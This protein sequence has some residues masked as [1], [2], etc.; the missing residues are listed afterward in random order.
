M[1]Y[2]GR[3]VGV[4]LGKETT[5]GTAVAASYFFPLDDYDYDD[6]AE[7]IA[8]EG[9]RSRIEASFGGDVVKKWGEGSLSGA[10]YN[11]GFGLVLLS[12]FG[13][14]T[15]TTTSGESAVY[16]HTFSVANSNEHQSLTISTDDSV[17]TDKRYAGAVVTSLE[18]KGAAGEYLTFNAGFMGNSEAS[19]TNTASYATEYPFRPQDI[20]F[21]LASAYSGLSGA[22]ATSIRS[23]TFKIEKNVEANYNLGSTSPSNFYNKQFTATLDI[24]ILHADDTYRDLFIAGTTRALQVTCA[25]TGV[26]LG[27]ASNP[28]L[29][30]DMYQGQMVDWS[31]SIS[32]DDISTETLSF[33]L[34]YSTADSKSIEVLLRNIVSSY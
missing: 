5:R 2:I 9:R 21:K 23:F 32:N 15:A 10:V 25:N 6:K 14:D 22:S 29:R 31:R 11:S 1:S 12:A 8:R 17:E 33:R 7:V 13:T 3:R 4:G 19:A 34:D 20:T 28:T 18:I 27:T 16:D 24:E 30:L 26:T